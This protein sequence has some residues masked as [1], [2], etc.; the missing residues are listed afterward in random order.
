MD[1]AT[2]YIGKNAPESGF[3]ILKGEVTHELFTH[4]L[5]WGFHSI[6]GQDISNTPVWD[7]DIS[8]NEKNSKI[9]YLKLEGNTNLNNYQLE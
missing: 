3:E 2:V 9:I 1:G 4:G 8:T 5:G 6:D 7:S